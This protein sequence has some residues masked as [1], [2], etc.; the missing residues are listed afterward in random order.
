MRAAPSAGAT[1]TGGAAPATLLLMVVALCH[2]LL[3]CDAHATTPPAGRV[4]L[5]GRLEARVSALEREF[6][7]K[8]GRMERQLER[9]ERRLGRCEAEVEAEGAGSAEAPVAQ[10]KW[11]RVQDQSPCRAAGIQ[12]MLASCC[13]AVSAG[14][15]DGGQHRREMQGTAVDGCAAFPSTCSAECAELFVSFYDTCRGE[16]GGVLVR[17]TATEWAPF[18]EFY[19]QCTEADQQAHS[20]ASR[21]PR[22]HFV[23]I[24]PD[25]EAKAQMR[26][27]VTTSNSNAPPPA[28]PQSDRDEETTEIQAACADNN[29]A[30]C[31]PACAVDTFGDFLMLTVMEDTYMMTCGKKDAGFSWVAT[32]GEGGTITT[33]ATVAQGQLSAGAPGPFHLALGHPATMLT[34]M[35]AGSGQRLIVKGSSLGH[36]SWSVN[37]NVVGFEVEALGSIDV[38]R[39]AISTTTSAAAAEIRRDGTARFSRC[40]FNLAGNGVVLYGGSAVID[41]TLFNG[42]C[43][44]CRAVSIAA[45]GIGS[46]VLIAGWV[47]HAA[48]S[49]LVDFD[50]CLMALDGAPAFRNSPNC[51]ATT[52]LSLSSDP[53]PWGLVSLVGDV[54]LSGDGDRATPALVQAEFF[55]AQGSSLTATGL[56]FQTDPSTPTFSGPGRVTVS[57]SEAVGIDGSRTSMSIACATLALDHGVTGG[58]CGGALG[59]TCSFVSCDEGY[60]L[61]AERVT[62]QCDLGGVWSGLSPSCEANSC[63]RASLANSDRTATNMC[64]GRTGDTC[65]YSCDEGYQRVGRHVCGPSGQFTGGS[66][67]RADLCLDDPTWEGPDG[68]GCAAHAVS[69]CSA[70][71]IGL[72]GRLAADACPVSCNRCTCKDE[73][74]EDPGPGGVACDA[75]KSHDLCGADAS[76]IGSLELAGAPLWTFCCNSC[77][78]CDGVAN[79]G[80][81]IDACGVCGGDGSSCV[82]CDGVAFSGMVSDACGVCGGGGIG[83][84]SGSAVEGSVCAAGTAGTQMG[85]LLWAESATGSTDYELCIDGDVETAFGTVGHVFSNG[86]EVAPQ[87]NLRVGTST[88]GCVGADGPRDRPQQCAWQDRFQVG[89]SASLVVSRL[90]F[91]RLKLPIAFGGQALHVSQCSFTGCIGSGWDAAAINLAG[92]ET[93]AVIVG[94]V[95]TSN[96]DGCKG[97]IFVNR[98]ASLV[99]QD[100][101]FERFSGRSR[102]AAC[103]GGAIQVIDT[104]LVI[105]RCQFLSNLVGY[106]GGALKLVGPSYRT[107]FLTLRNTTFDSNTVEG[108]DEAIFFTDPPARFQQVLTNADAT[109]LACSQGVDG[110]GVC[111]GDNGTCAGCDGIPHSGLDVNDCGTCGFDP[112][113][114]CDGEWHSSAMPALDYCGVCGGD[115]STCDPCEMSVGLCQNGATCVVEMEMVFRC[116]CIGGFGGEQCEIELADGAK[117]CGD[118]P[119][120]GPNAGGCN[121]SGRGCHDNGMACVPEWHDCDNRC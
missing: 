71:T 42:T 15:R 119:P 80:A 24:A 25:I 27:V 46:E 8:M 35:V 104:V 75:I 44:V 19:A 108:R 9:M 92:G 11:R 70:D 1:A 84:A 65:E 66:C 109:A 72:D 114:G 67:R 37:R 26:T 100:T 111:G 38:T 102:N 59:D 33:D 43:R 29:L 78:G 45:G 68:S 16:E 64:E 62:R 13:P 21:I 30:E 53:A 51:P 116:Q 106:P 63:A 112:Q 6:A 57:N 77:A 94:T 97:T 28:T 32:G 54:A 2:N 5:D 52:S 23:A 96:R 99:V 113:C 86:D 115:G 34:T 61:S 105:D 93:R 95:F 83:C 12:T 4:L 55:I 18:D 81:E 90:A 107:G 88:V 17:M 3:P 91:D 76:A 39:L 49:D 73:I 82:G 79:S 87:I 22:T 103:G 41:H 31:A 50:I 85:F 120:C 14:G 56:D 48:L 121:G 110:C 89:G 40:T 74:D 20:F 98:C 47:T 101:V 118:G 10:N 7:A 58:Q 36:V 60:T 117:C 69:G